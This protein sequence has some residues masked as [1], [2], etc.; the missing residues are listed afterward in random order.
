MIWC[1][2]FTL[3]SLADADL[4]VRI[5]LYV[6]ITIVVEPEVA[7]VDRVAIWRPARYVF[8]SGVSVLETQL[9]CSQF[10]FCH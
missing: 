1:Q 6:T 3:C 4:V 8:P 9:F 2:M 10:A 5:A 7:S